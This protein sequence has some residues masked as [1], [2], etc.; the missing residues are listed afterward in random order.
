MKISVSC[1]LQ[2]ED[3][4]SN[5]GTYVAHFICYAW[6]QSGRSVKVI[7][8]LVRRLE[9]RVVRPIAV[10]YRVLAS[11]CLTCTKNFTVL[12]RDLGKTYER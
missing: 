3:R 8:R 11:W 5:A 1:W 9:T 12:S 7:S 4:S 10:L 6:V 2:A